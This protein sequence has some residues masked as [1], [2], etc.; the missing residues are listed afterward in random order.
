MDGELKKSFLLNQISVTPFSQLKENTLAVLRTI[1]RVFEARGQRRY[2]R[3]QAKGHSE[4]LINVK[5]K[6]QPIKGSI[7]DLSTS[8]FI[9][10]VPEIYHH[11]FRVGQY[12][13]EVLLVLR[14]M[15]IRTA[16]KIVGYSKNKK[17][18]FILKYCSLN[19]K[20]GRIQY[21]ELL[22]RERKQKL[23]GYIRSCLREE[24]TMRLSSA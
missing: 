1:L 14:G 9:C 2:I 15:R 8:A 10:D 21:E 4:A 24:L 17:N 20:G 11:H 13:E 18:E 5:G 3:V 23:C 6:E 19:M 22:G 7:K 16:V 12:L